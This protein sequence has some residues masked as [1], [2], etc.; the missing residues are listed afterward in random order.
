MTKK[1]RALLPSVIA[2]LALAW[3][4]YCSIT[5]LSN[6]Y[7]LPLF[8]SSM[9]QGEVS[10]CY[11]RAS[12]Y[13]GRVIIIHYLISAFQGEVSMCQGVISNDYFLISNCQG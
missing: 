5:H 4:G 9:Y 6:I 11:G 3:V 8:C 10:M 1:V 2:L 7:F 12:N 13:Q